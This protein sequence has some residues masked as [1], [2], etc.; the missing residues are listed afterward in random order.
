[1]S[2]E[3]CRGERL[4]SQ[5][6]S[7]A[8]VA[9]QV[10]EWCIERRRGTSSVFNPREIGVV[11]VRGGL[12]KHRTWCGEK[13]YV[14][15]VYAAVERG[16]Q[17]PVRANYGGRDGNRHKEAGSWSVGRGLGGHGGDRRKVSGQY[18]VTSVGTA[19][20]EA[21]WL[22]GNEYGRARAGGGL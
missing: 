19:E 6:V 7:A 1:M 10:G 9:M 4:L 21:N 5:M 11:E 16:G 2:F 22:D 3:R 20:T 13:I 14:G 18:A 12:R 15:G 8:E 17:G